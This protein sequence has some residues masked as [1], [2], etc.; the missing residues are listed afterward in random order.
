[1]RS[2][3]SNGSYSL[4]IRCSSSA[5]PG[6]FINHPFTIGGNIP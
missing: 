5:T 6:S 1:L 4:S 3:G 2:M